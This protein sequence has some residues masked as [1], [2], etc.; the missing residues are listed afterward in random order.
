MYDKEKAE[1]YASIIFDRLNAFEQDALE[2]IGRRIKEIGSLSAFD[3]QA[4]KN[5][6]DI[7]RDMDKITKELARITELNSEHEIYSA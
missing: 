4:L 7:S 1:Q 6:A 5:M 2:T 3:S